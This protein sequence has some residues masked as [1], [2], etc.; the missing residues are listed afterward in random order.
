LKLVEIH[1]NSSKVFEIR[2]N[3]SNF[4]KFVEI[5]PIFRNS[6]KFIQFF[7]IRWNLSK[8]SKFVEIH[9]IYNIYILSLRI[10]R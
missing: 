1:R 7:E 2:W 3:L 4:S 10:Y 8:F 6:L 9:R 5:Y